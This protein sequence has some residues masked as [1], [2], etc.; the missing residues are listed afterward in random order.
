MVFEKRDGGFEPSEGLLGRDV[1]ALW[2]APSF[3][4]SVSF[5]VLGIALL[6]TGSSLSGPHEPIQRQLTWLCVCIHGATS[7][8]PAMS[9]SRSKTD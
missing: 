5:G 8:E 9:V 6:F 1:C 2:H 3:G 7:P 4:F